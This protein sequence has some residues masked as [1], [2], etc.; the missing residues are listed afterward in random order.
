[1]DLI[2]MQGVSGSGKS[3]TAAALAFY[4]NSHL[5]KECLI[6]STD[7]YFYNKV[8]TNPE[9]YDF[10]PKLLGE[11]HKWNQERVLMALTDPAVDV[12]IVDNTNTQQAHA[13]IYFD[14]ARENGWDVRVV[15][16]DAEEKVITQANQ[17][18]PS[19]RTI[20]P[21]VVNKQ[22]KHLKKLKLD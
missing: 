21:E 11:A 16:V 15:S 9:K 2:V 7:E 10:N 18:R 5:N 3:F 14:M 19:D 6:F 12:V 8:G 4:Y 22:R 13:Q 17:D 1:M 20:P